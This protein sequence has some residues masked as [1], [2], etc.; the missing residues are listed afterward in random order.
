MV[1]TKCCQVF[2]RRAVVFKCRTCHRRS[3]PSKQAS[4]QASRLW[5][6]L[7]QKFL[8]SQDM[9]WL[10]DGRNHSIIQSNHVLLW[11]I[12]ITHWEPFSVDATG[13]PRGRFI[14]IALQPPS[15]KNESLRRILPRLSVWHPH[16]ALHTIAHCQKF[17]SKWRTRVRI[18]SLMAAKSC[19]EMYGISKKIQNTTTTTHKIP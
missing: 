8:E 19:K 2:F 6:I 4:K 16:W 18:E 12:G 9:I 10:T 3:C 14:P 5:R 1:D 11:Q 17:G 15:T 7:T 13:Q